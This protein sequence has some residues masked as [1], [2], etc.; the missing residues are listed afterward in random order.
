MTGPYFVDANV[1]VYSRDP[2]DR[3]KQARAEQWMRVLFRER[4]GR[5]S[6][7]VLSE[8]YSVMTR[9]LS[10]RVPSEL[11]WELVLVLLQWDPQAVDAPLLVRARDVE[12]R[13]RLSW[14]DSLVVAAAQVQNCAVL[15]TED[16]QDGAVMGTVTVRSPF[17]LELREPGATYATTP[18][19][20]H[21]H[22]PR[23]RPRR[24]ALA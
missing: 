17:T 3:A 1:L 22:R 20:A 18:A 4:I 5:T 2:R 21:A 12:S 6:A 10:P 24:T 7:Q 8:Y 23:G 15:L 14:W 13:W 16:L 9:K 11:A 19:V